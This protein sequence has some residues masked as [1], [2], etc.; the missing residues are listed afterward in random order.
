MT[1]NC[2][3]FLKLR[4]K[5]IEKE[6]SRMND[7]QLE[8]VLTING[9]LLILAGAG[10][11]KTT[12]LVNRIANLVR[13]G[14]AYVTDA[15]NFEPEDGDIAFLEQYLNGEHMQKDSID[16]MLAHNAAQP[17]QI[18][19]ITF[20]N[21][22]ANELKNR[23]EL[24]LPSGAKDIWAST[25]HSCCSRILRRYA[26]RLGYTN[27]FTIYDTDDQKKAIKEALKRLNIDEKFLPVK[28]IMS[29]ISHS[30]D[31][32]ISPEEYANQ[33]QFDFRKKSV[34]LVYTEYQQILKAS[35][36]MDFDDLICKTVEL[37]R[38]NEDILQYYQRKFKYVLV[39]EYQDTNH[40]QYLLTSLLAG[41]YNNLCVVGDDDQSIYRF[42]GATIENILS[43]ENEYR[44]AK[45]IRLE[46]N[47]RSTGTILDAAN[48][49]IKNNS[50][51]KGKNLW[52]DA[53]DGE[54]IT[55]YT[56][57]DETKESEYI[58][59][60]IVD[61][62]KKDGL[63][64]SDHAILYRMNAQSN[65]I[66]RS[67]IRMGIPY[68][69][70]GGH[71]FYDR[72]EIKDALAYLQLINNT[73]DSIRLRRIINE[74]K[75]GIGEASVNYAAEIA[76]T[77]GLSIFEV[78]KN[79]DQYAKLSRGA[80][81][82]MKFAQMIEDLQEFAQ[83]ATLKE[84]F[85]EL[86]LQTG[87]ES[88]LSNDPE[89]CDERRENLRELATNLL[90]YSEENPDGDLSG[91]LEEVAL[92]TDIDN[93]D[94]TADSVVMMTL[95]SSKGL[96]FPVVFIPGMEEGV[97]PSMQ[98]MYD[99]SEVEEERRLAYVGITRAKQKLHITN[100][101]QRMLFGKTSRNRPSRFAMEIPVSCID[102]KSDIISRS[103]VSNTIGT[104]R[105][106]YSGKPSFGSSSFGSS[107]TS[108]ATSASAKSSASSASA[109]DFSVGD[110]VKSRI[111][112]E[113]TIINCQKMGND[114]LLEVAFDSVGT[115]KLMAKHAKLSKI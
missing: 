69:I 113:G 110:R 36:A 50:K 91:F 72:K 38:N 52:T 103:F 31:S 18:L 11:G 101:Q 39:D 106:T 70:F 29:E 65:T 30:K 73:S 32:M 100:T 7:K 4:R 102:K 9:P 1:E 3:K 55:L 61:S 87:Y 22:A 85:D 45:V 10:S 97:F 98:T 15:I 14:D 80:K 89:T 19:A 42:R 57:S 75:R 62:V 95:H 63:K 112:G 76:Q 84:L 71:K 108:S 8:A 104:G 90:K 58:A 41:G 54:K 83:T 74:P 60:S 34:A 33:Y 16:A 53:G 26:D 12:V 81:G 96:E 66:E 44:N 115:K 56:A 13:F 49:V 99:D 51:R 64:W 109:L 43:F 105:N 23:L 86:M 27:S 40:A 17:W 46:Q 28:Y 35:D 114:M 6:F 21:K 78:I 24:M 67:F 37:L 25:F 79:A 5:I 111:F 82:L 107:Y 94:E 48:A 59:D 47:Y 68:R 92:M 2:T 77:L 93:Y 88:S 20:T